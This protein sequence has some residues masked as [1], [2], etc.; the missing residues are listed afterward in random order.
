VKPWV[1]KHLFIIINN[2]ANQLDYIYLFIYFVFPKSV[3]CFLTS[4][5]LASKIKESFSWSMFK[6]KQSSPDKKFK[7]L[8]LNLEISF[9]VLGENVR[10]GIRFHLARLKMISLRTT[11]HSNLIAGKWRGWFGKIWIQANVLHLRQLHMV[12]THDHDI[13]GCWHIIVYK[14]ISPN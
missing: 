3:I 13:G 8:W 9:L 7:F 4:F 5:S 1:F 12:L 2:R 6:D 11:S 10:T 14:S